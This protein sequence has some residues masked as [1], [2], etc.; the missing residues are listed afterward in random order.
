[1]LQH[2][3]RGARPLRASQRDG[4]PELTTREAEVLRW[5]NHPD[6]LTYAEIGAKLGIDRRTVEAHRDKLFEKFGVHKRLALLRRA[7]ELGLL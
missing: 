3:R 4:V 2:L 6:G 7:T 5:M 1:M